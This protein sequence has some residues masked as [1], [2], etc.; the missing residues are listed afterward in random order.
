MNEEPF[1]TLEECFGDMVDPRVVGR[2][3]HKLVEIILVAICA[4]L[5][6]AESWSEIEEFGVTKE[7]WLRQY[8]ELPG[9]IPSHDTFGRVF[10]LLDAME[11]QRRFMGWVAAHFS[12]KQGQVIAVDGKTARGSHDAYRGQTAIHLVS[13]W[14]QESGLLLGQRKVD[15]KSNE[16]TAVPELLKLLFIKG[17]VVTVDALNCQKDIAQTI[18]DQQADYLFALKANHPLLHQEIVEWFAWAQERQFRDV[19]H[20][21]HETVNKGHGRVEIRRCWAISDPLAFEALAYYDGW[22]NLGSIA[23]IQRQRQLT[24][25]LQSETVYYLS[26]LPADAARL[27][28]VSRSH[29]AVE[30]AFHWTLDVIFA[31]DASRVRLDDAPENFAVL[32]HIAL[33]LL[34]R[35]PA[36]LSLNRKRFRAALNDSFLLALLTQF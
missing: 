31:E 5:C 36:K 4:V 21:F 24:D 6:G 29:W 9:G 2:C 11:F 23:M 13:A 15:D 7:G 22:A 28:E 12:V 30:N 34:K 14:A 8:L 16:I 27:L 1:A 32:R 19:A 3:D 10:R 18:V 26:S 33:N 25:R 17:C 20:S 35:H